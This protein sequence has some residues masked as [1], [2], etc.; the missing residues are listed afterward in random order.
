MPDTPPEKIY[1][2]EEITARLAASLADWRYED[3]HIRRR[4]KTANWPETLMVINAVGFLAETA[5][6]HPTLSASYSWAEFSLM[7]HSAGGITDKDFELARKIEDLVV[8]RP[9]NEGGALQG[10]PKRQSGP[11]S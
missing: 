3:G 4:Y 8:W 9:G 1:T 10:K 6:H 7:T 5:W 11:P 2:P